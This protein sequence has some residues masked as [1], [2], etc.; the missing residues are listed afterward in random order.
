M[1]RLATL[2]S[3]IC[4]SVGSAQVCSGE[5]SFGEAPL[6]FFGGGALNGYFEFYNAGLLLGNHAVFG[7]LGAGLWT[8]NTVD[9]ESFVVSGTFG[10][11]LPHAPQSKTQICPVASIMIVNG[12]QN[13]AGSGFDYHDTDLSI[14]LNAGYVLTHVGPVEFVPTTSITAMHSS[15]SITDP[16]GAK[17]SRGTAF[18]YLGLG[19]GI[20]FGPEVSLSPSVALP[21][22]N[23]AGHTQFRFRFVVRLKDS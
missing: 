9:G 17:A 6:H 18:G 15:A 20:R 21:L 2:L 12:P 11:E 14:G 10:V 4:T 3:V 16:T 1:L 13:I 5:P 19:L 7:E 23:G 8:Y 22:G